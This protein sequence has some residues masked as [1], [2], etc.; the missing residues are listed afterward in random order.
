MVPD[1]DVIV[2]T[3]VLKHFKFCLDL[4]KCFF[5][6]AVAPSSAA[7]QHLT[8]STSNFQVHFDGKMGHQVKLEEK[9]TI[10]QLYG[11]EGYKMD[12]TIQRRFQSEE[13]G[14]IN[15]GWLVKSNCPGKRV[16]PLMAVL[17][18]YKDK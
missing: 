2:G 15:S 10:T 13:Q 1:V 11:T 17:Q 16:I 8:M 4:Q 5:A 7:L 3:D 12:E 9:A 14:L 18:E 6:T